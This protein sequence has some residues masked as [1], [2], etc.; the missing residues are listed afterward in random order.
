VGSAR[1][2]ASRSLSAAEREELWA[3]LQ[4][5]R[6]AGLADYRRLDSRLHLYIGELVGAPSLIPV[7]ADNRMQ[8]NVLLD[9]IPLLERN[10]VHSN[11]Q[12]EQIVVAILTGQPDK[13]A[14]AMA[15]HLEGSASLLR[16]FLG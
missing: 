14:E 15:E 12:H 8:V 13:A 11:E 10:I 4:D 9:D 3:R 5:V 2:A 1:S 16:G 6:D 7:L